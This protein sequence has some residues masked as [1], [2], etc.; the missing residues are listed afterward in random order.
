MRKDNINN[1]LIGFIRPKICSLKMVTN[2]FR[3]YFIGYG[4]ILILGCI[5]NQSQLE[6]S[7]YVRDIN[8]PTFKLRKK[9]LL[10]EVLEKPL[11]DQM[12]LMGNSILRKYGKT[13]TEGFGAKDTSV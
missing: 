13:G 7:S 12:E 9:Y 5:A 2:S 1:L 4:N 6:S 3:L 10:K 8:D 11:E